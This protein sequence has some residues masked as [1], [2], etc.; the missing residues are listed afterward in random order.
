[1]Q[2]I[3][4]GN[5]N[6]FT[7]KF[8]KRSIIGII[9]QILIVLCK[10]FYNFCNKIE[11][12][13]LGLFTKQPVKI[14][15]I[16]VSISIRCFCNLWVIR[17]WVRIRATNRQIWRWG[18]IISWKSGNFSYFIFLLPGLASPS[19]SD[20]EDAIFSNFNALA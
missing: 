8:T 7:M 18:C 9:F 11:S 14:T 1:M 3:S 2:L 20:S 10:M 13:L 17:S 6:S 4:I 12:C 19:C 5:R 16:S 15:G